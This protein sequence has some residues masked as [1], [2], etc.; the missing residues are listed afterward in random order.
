MHILTPYR[1]QG[2][3]RKLSHMP[4]SLQICIAQGPHSLVSSY[5]HGDCEDLRRSICMLNSC[6]FFIRQNT[7]NVLALY[8]HS[9]Q[10][11]DYFFSSLPELQ[12]R[13]C[14]HGANAIVL[15]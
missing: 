5:K 13:F 6:K 8:Y 1:L 11:R 14:F 2:R 15:I 10:G 4:Q 7:R 9:L 12:A 3:L